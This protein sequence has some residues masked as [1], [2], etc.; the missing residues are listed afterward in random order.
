LVPPKGFS[1]Y[2]KITVWSFKKVKKVSSAEGTYK[3]TKSVKK[4]VSWSNK[5]IYVQ[6]GYSK[7][8]IYA[9]YSTMGNMKVTLR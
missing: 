5:K 9:P 8:R 6:T 7:K 1:G 4:R 2:R 3:I